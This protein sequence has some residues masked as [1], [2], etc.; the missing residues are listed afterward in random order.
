VFFT[1]AALCLATQAVS[2]EA[3]API[4]DEQ[5]AKQP[6]VGSLIRV[7]LP[8]TGNVD[9]R[10]KA[11][12]QR[13]QDRAKQHPG[14]RPVLVLEFVPSGSEF[15]EGTDFTRALGLARYLSSRQLAGVKTVAYVPRTIRGH[16]VLVAMACEE[17]IM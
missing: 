8:L 6:A 10:I 16:A 15:G 14:E 5:P 11:M 7:P 9:N 2:Q 17:I 4:A 12:I 3:P 13:V 1:L